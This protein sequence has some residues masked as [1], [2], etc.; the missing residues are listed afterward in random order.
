MYIWGRVVFF[1]VCVW[2][3]GGGGGELLLL[4]L[5]VVII[6]VFFN[7]SALIMQIKHI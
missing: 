2:E 7:T 4:L 5:N 3:G 1:P 6:N